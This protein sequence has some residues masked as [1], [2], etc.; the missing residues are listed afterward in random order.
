MSIP[1]PSAYTV[2]A[3]DNLWNISKQ[4]TGSGSNWKS[5]KGYSGDPRK[6]P[7]GTKIS[8]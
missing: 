2:R 5:L 7:V 1:R 3:G 8:L 4:L 6:L